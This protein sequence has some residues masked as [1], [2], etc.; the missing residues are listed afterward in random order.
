M[1]PMC[2]HRHIIADDNSTNGPQMQPKFLWRTASD[3]LEWARSCYWTLLPMTT[4]DQCFYQE[5]IPIRLDRPIIDA[6]KCCWWP[7]MGPVCLAT[8]VTNFFGWTHYCCWKWLPMSMNEPDVPIKN[9]CRWTRNG[10]IIA[11]EKCCWCPQSCLVFLP[12]IAVNGLGIGPLS[13]LKNAANV[14]DRA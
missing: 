8:M 3:A 11:S 1:L 14:H 4:M 5:T 2:L 12:R 7:W 6:E 9:C 10:P 13:L